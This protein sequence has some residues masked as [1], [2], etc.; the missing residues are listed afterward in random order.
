MLGKWDSMDKELLFEAWD[1]DRTPFWRNLPLDASTYVVER[2]FPHSNSTR[3]PLFN[4]DLTRRWEGRLA[5]WCIVAGS[6]ASS[7]PAIQVT[8][9]SGNVHTPWLPGAESVIGQAVADEGAMWNRTGWPALAE[10]RQGLV[11][12]PLRYDNTVNNTFTARDPG[13]YP[14]AIRANDEISGTWNDATQAQIEFGGRAVSVVGGSVAMDGS[15][16]PAPA[17]VTH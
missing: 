12:A 15:E 14:F 16:R 11:K 7:L 5:L 10:V 8:T 1:D 6:V 17:F 4:N 13:I 9:H 3:V 2:L